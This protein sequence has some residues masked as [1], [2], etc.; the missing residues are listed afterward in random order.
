MSEFSC[1]VCLTAK[2]SSYMKSIGSIEDFL[3]ADK[4]E[5]LAYQQLLFRYGTKAQ[6]ELILMAKKV[7]AQQEFIHNG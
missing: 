6:Q 5:S 1:L 7:V 3:A 2:V 4:L